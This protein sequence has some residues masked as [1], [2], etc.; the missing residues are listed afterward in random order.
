MNN[1]LSAALENLYNPFSR[2]S[3]NDKNYKQWVFRYTFLE[4]EK[5]LGINGDVTSLSTLKEN[6]PGRA[7]VVAKQAGVVAGI[8]ELNYFLADSDK[9][10]KP[11]LR[12]GI[13]VDFKVFDG[14]TVEAGQDIAILEGG[15]LDLLAV[16]RV[17][18][19]LLMR[20]SGVATTTRRFVDMIEGS[21][22]SVAATRKTLW[23]L[24]D[25]KAVMVGGGLPH[26][27]NLSD[28]VLV[29]D[30]H[31]DLMGRDFP[32]L[33]GALEKNFA[34]GRFLEV[35]VET[36]EEAKECF[37]LMKGFL[38]GRGMF[39]V[40]MFDNFSP[41]NLG[42]AMNHFAELRGEAPNIFFEA[43]GGVN[44]DSIKEYAK[45][46]VDVVSLSALTMSAKPIDF[47]MKFL[48]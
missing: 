3:I 45:S 28:A 39:G 25:K 36:L 37:S 14:E 13:V 38:D 22:V 20:M 8:E 5:D 1:N 2:L 43:S 33:F 34:S 32:K 23:G 48:V 46:A 40:I 41:E 26:R 17:C 15:V 11:S 44:E 4:L 21:G 30:T 19:N 35:E 31:L 27:L 10:F 29:K 47:S 24:L 18:L 7:R 6:F 12:G 42:V 16:E 9:A